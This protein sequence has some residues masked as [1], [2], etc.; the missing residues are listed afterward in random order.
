[1]STV[2]TN[3]VFF[4]SMAGRKQN[5]INECKFFSV[6]FWT[7]WGFHFWSAWLSLTLV[8]TAD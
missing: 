8:V 5:K 6:L 3:M 1:M 7:L 2:T 4:V